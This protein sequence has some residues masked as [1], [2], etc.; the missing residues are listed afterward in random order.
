MQ[1][2]YPRQIALLGARTAGQSDKRGIVIH[3]V[4]AGQMADLRSLEG[5]SAGPIYEMPVH[6]DDVFQN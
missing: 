1:D 2:T 5:K 4:V 6:V 3:F